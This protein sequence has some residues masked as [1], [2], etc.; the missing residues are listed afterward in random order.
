MTKN[1]GKEAAIPVDPVPYEPLVELARRT[2]KSGL[3]GTRTSRPQ[4]EAPL[5]RPLG[6]FVTLWDRNQHLR[7]CIGHL[8]PVCDNVGEEVMECAMAAATRDP[9]FPPMEPVELSTTSIELSMVLPSEAI[10]SLDELD[11]AVYGVIVE[12]GYRL[13]TLL[14][15]ID[16]VETAEQQVEIARQKAGIGPDEPVKMRRYRVIKVKERPRRPPP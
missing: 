4:L 14:P 7:G 3:L 6:V 11:P 2:I 16:G 8:E 15:D 9:R 13:G 10:Q 12:S 1:K 5:D